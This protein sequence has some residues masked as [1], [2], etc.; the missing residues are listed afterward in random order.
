LCFFLYWDTVFEDSTP[1]ATNEMY[2]ILWQRWI[3]N[4]WY[5]LIRVANAIKESI[6]MGDNLL[7]QYSKINLC[8][9]LHH[10]TACNTLRRPR[11]RAT[12][13][14]PSIS[15]LRWAKIN[16]CIATISPRS[17]AA[18]MAG[19]SWIP[20]TIRRFRRITPPLSKTL[21]RVA[22]AWRE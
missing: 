2:F 7:Y 10:A 12:V 5:T 18:R 8:R 19:V 6:R 21:V 14:G 22:Q 20:G 11:W 16:R 9:L 4:Y 17:Y 3:A 13:R 15:R 1:V